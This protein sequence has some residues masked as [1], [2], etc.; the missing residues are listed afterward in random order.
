MFRGSAVRGCWMVAFILLA[1]ALLTRTAV[2]LHTAPADVRDVVKYIYDDGYYYLTV[3]ANVADLGRSTFDGLTATNGYQPLWLWILSGLA[4]ITGTAPYT[5][6]VACCLLI[7]AIALLSPLLAFTWRGEKRAI[8][9]S[10]CAGLALV[11]LHQPVIFLQG[12]EAVLMLP[13]AVPLCILLERNDGS[14]KSLIALSALMAVVFLVRLD[15]LAV[16]V[17]VILG[18]LT[19]RMRLGGNGHQHLMARLRQVVLLSLVVI[20]VVIAYLVANAL[21]FGSPVPVSGLAKSIGAPMF[22]NWGVI[23]MFLD[24]VKPLSA[25][26]ALVLTLEFFARSV[27]IR[28]GTV[29]YRS[30]AVVAVAASLQAFYYCA[31]SSWIVWPW[32]TY[33]ISVCMALLFARIFHLVSLLVAVRR[34]P[35]VIALALVAAWALNLTY[36]LVRD[37]MPPKTNEGQLAEISPNQLSLEMLGT[38]FTPGRHE[39]IAMGDRAGGLGYWGRGR[40]SIVQT[41]GLVLDAGYIR[42]RIAGLGARYLE[43]FPLNYL[44][45]DREQFAQVQDGSGRTQIVIP[46]PIEGRVNTGPVPVFCFPPNAIRYQRAYSW[47]QKRL[48]FDFSQREACSPKAL[49]LMRTV[50]TG[51]GLRQ[52]SLPGD[53]V[54]GGFSKPAEDRDRHFHGVAPAFTPLVIPMTAPARQ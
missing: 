5:L 50:E 44:V 19:G 51:I 45:V 9:L 29:F 53:Y 2:L 37:S 1:I 40:V 22:S 33:L 31:F 39:L 24:R 18:V 32:Y 13:L 15:G 6:F 25:L 14:E 12:L 43:Q 35:A 48:V 41:E 27:A 42:A 54:V 52:F 7:Y 36:R 10:L 34:V 28:S 23:V 20:P 16:Y 11:T 38:F 46:D 8:A 26:L 49:D 30:L 4:R 3:A 47:N 21:L 17:V